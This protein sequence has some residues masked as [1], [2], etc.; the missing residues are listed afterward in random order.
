VRDISVVVLT[1][2]QTEHA[3]G[4]THSTDAGRLLPTFP[5]ARYVV[6]KAAW[7][8][9]CHADERNAHLYDAEQLHPLLEMEQIELIEG[10]REIVPGVWTRP[11]PGPT[12]GHQIVLA[13]W[14]GGIM[15]FLGLLSPTLMHLTSKVVSASDKSPENS[16][17]SKKAVLAQ[18]VAEDWFVA[19][20]GFDGWI[21]GGDLEQLLTQQPINVGDV[22]TI[23]KRLTL[24]TAS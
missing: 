22:A 9:A 7:E 3:G 12:A 6:Q 17:A 10:E 19:P 24:A 16:L 14:A 15:A 20:V 4:A 1:H 23:T 5:K 8:E 13:E 21:A 11:A 18:A 2:L